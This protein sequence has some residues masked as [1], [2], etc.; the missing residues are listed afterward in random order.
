MRTIYKYKLAVTDVQYIDLPKG[1]K[2]LHVG[3]SHGDIF[4]WCELDQID[5]LESVRFDVHGTGHIIMKTDSV[6]LGTVVSKAGFVW[7]VYHYPA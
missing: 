5:E 4:I 1:Y 2:I 6:H 7:H 3:E